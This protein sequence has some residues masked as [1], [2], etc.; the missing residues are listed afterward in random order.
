MMRFIPLF[1]VVFFSLFGL[2]YAHG[3]DIVDSEYGK[4]KSL[5][6]FTPPEMELGPHVAA[7]GMRFYTGKMFPREYNNNIFIAEHGSWNRST[8]I[9]YR[10]MIVTLKDNRAIRYDVFAEGWL[11]GKERWGRPVDVQ[12]MPDGSLLVSD[13]FAGVIYRI[14]YSEKE[15]NKR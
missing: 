7:L 6:D 5:R 2:S 14:T 15:G 10:V 8:P 12:V 11:Q 1:A 13:D 9:G 3:H 4:G